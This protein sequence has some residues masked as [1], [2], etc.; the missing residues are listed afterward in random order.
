MCDTLYDAIPFCFAPLTDFA[1]DGSRIAT[2]VPGASSAPGSASYRLIVVP[3]AGDTTLA[4]DY[5][6]DPISVPPDTVES[7]LALRLKNETRQE[8][9]VAYRSVK[10]P[11]SYPALS[12]VL[13]GRDDTIWLESTAAPATGSGGW[14]APT[15]QLLATLRSREPS[16]SWWRRVRHSGEPIR[17][18]TTSRASCATGYRVRRPVLILARW[19]PI[20][21]P[22]EFPRIPRDSAYQN[23]AGF[24]T[25]ARRSESRDFMETRK[26]AD[27]RE[28]PRI[29]SCGY[30]LK[31]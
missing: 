26:C 18:R 3:A 30:G 23:L 22:R 31:T 2:V 14:S 17:T 29:Q 5:T 4:R 12:R 7:V 9:I 19:F 13:V 25:R 6:Y 21:R 16:T 27:E 8:F 28:S 24:P 15:A 11:D 1:P 10:P 20:E